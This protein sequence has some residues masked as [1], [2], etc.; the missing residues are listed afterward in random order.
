MDQPT[1][2]LHIGIAPV[3]R[4]SRG[5]SFPRPEVPE[6]APVPAAETLVLARP[7]TGI[8]SHAFF[9]E[10][11]PNACSSAGTPGPAVRNPSATNS[12]TVR[13]R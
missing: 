13:T 12:L 5:P 10:D 2:E 11:I 4:P 8:D 1:Q 9:A 3:V 6:L 7:P